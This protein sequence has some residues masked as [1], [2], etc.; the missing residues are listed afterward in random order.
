MR[1]FLSP[2]SQQ[3]V[4]QGKLLIVVGGLDIPQ[5]CGNYEDLV[6]AVTAIAIDIFTSYIFQSWLIPVI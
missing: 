4:L 1:K 5:G 2:T 3:Q 6:T